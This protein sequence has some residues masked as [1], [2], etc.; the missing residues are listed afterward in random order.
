MADG[1]GRAVLTLAEEVWRAARPGRRSTPSAWSRSCSGARRSTTRRRTAITISSR[2]CTNACAAPIPTPRSTISRACSTP[3][4]TR[5][6]SRGASAHG[7]RGHRACR[8]AGARRR[9]RREGRLRFPGH[10]RGEL[11]IAEAV[12]YVATAPKSNA[13]YKAFGAAQALAKAHGSPAPPKTIL[14]APT[15]L[16]RREG[17]ARLINTTT[18]RPTPSA[19]RTTGPTSSAAMRSTSRSNAASSASCASGS[20]IGR[21]C[22]R[23]EAVAAVHSPSKTGVLPDALWTAADA[24]SDRVYRARRRRLP[25]EGRCAK[26]FSLWRRETPPRS[27]LSARRLR[28][29]RQAACA[30]PWLDP[31]ALIPGRGKDRRLIEP[32]CCVEFPSS[33]CTSATVAV[34]Q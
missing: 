9:Q 20:T 6:S 27:L 16:M 15:G 17:Y 30:W 11:A 13:V 26:P 19:A 1:D 14:N 32:G 12:V 24:I 2:P 33:S 21:G 3:A 25:A 29:G 5:C 10:A 22:G 7:V 31:A 18:T 28:R 34:F 23:S 8:P 4:R